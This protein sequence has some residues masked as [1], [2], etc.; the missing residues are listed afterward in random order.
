MEGWMIKY[1]MDVCAGEKGEPNIS[2]EAP[3]LEM[4]HVPGV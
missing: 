4:V 2:V 3:F 1:R